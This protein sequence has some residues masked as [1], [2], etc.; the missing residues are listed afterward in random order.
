[1][2]LR[3]VLVSVPPVLLVWG[4]SLPLG[5]GPGSG[6][7]PLAMRLAAMAVLIGGGLWRFCLDAQD[8]AM[9]LRLALRRGSAPAQPSSP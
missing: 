4:A 1:L 5:L 6:L 2:L 9:L 7:G 8:R 3:I